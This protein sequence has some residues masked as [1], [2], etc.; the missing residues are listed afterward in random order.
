MTQTGHTTQTPGLPF[1]LGTI[2][3]GTS[4][5]EADT[6][7]LLDRYVDAGGTMIDTANNYPFWMA[8]CTGDE[9]E[10]VIGRWLAAR[11]SRDRVSIGTKVGARPRTAGDR[12]LDDLEG[13]SA[14]VIRAGIEASLRRLQTDRVDMYWAHVDDRT[15]SLAKTVGAFDDLIRRGLVRAVGASNLVTWRV[16]QARAIARAGG[17]TPFT[18]VQMRHTYV[19]PRPGLRAETPVQEYV[20]DETLDYVRE[21]PDVT[22][23]AYSTLLEGAYTRPDRPIPDRYQYSGTDARLAALSKVADELGATP[24]QVVLAWLIADGIVPIVGVSTAAQLDEAIA[25]T[26][27]TLDADIRSVLDSTW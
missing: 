19:R 11:R 17:H 8:G 13:L 23:W 10:C 7:A 25:A 27:L 9:S 4:V 3:F 16:V 21:H 12:T 22:L 15:V 14:P 5:R 20:T 2:P 26:R 24:N 6:F 1:A 18:A